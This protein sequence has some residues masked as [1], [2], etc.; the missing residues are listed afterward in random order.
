[1]ISQEES[2]RTLYGDFAPR[3]LPRYT[4]AQ[5]ARYA[6][7]SPTTVRSWVRGRTYPKGGA[8]AHSE[9]LIEVS[10]DLLS[11]SHVIEVHVLRALRRDED[12]RMAHLRAAI[13][14]AKERYQIDRPLLSEQLRTGLGE[15][16]LEQY[17]QLIKLRP[18]GQLALRHY[19]DAH[20]KR[21]EWDPQGWPALF[22]PGF[23][24]VTPLPPRDEQTT[25]LIVVDPGVSFGKPV[26]A[27]RKGIRVSA[28]VSRIDA[29]E[30]EEAVARDY[31]ITVLEVNAAIDFYERAA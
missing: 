27:S 18:S 13:T 21:V 4:L 14:I 29:G 24:H 17:G 8:S 6:R 25:R 31:G 19:F 22:F 20:L 30:Q 15:L 26:L 1:M 23:V 2:A 7:V 28:I 16:L 3:D 12:V 5:A 9:P 11:F 10:S